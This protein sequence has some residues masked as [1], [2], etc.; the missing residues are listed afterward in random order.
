MLVIASCLRCILGEELIQT[1]DVDRGEA[2]AAHCSVCVCVCVC[3]LRLP[4]GSK[5]EGTMRD[6]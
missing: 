5:A 6:S 4:D 2:A 1:D 3:V